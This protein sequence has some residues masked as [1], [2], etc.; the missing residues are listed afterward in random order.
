MP[1]PIRTEFGKFPR[2]QHR[3]SIIIHP[4]LITPTPSY[5][6]PRWNFRKANCDAFTRD[7][8]S[9]ACSLDKHCK[10]NI[11]KC[12]DALIYSIKDLAKKHIPRGFRKTYV[13]GWNEEC[14]ILAK[15]HQEEIRETADKLIDHLE[16]TRTERWKQT[17][18]SIN[19]THSSREA[20]S[21][22]NINRLIGRKKSS[23]KQA[24]APRASED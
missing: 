15:Q 20:W 7:S 11:N 18:E 19:F 6:V 21:T 4:A 16:Q 9:L 23:T 10:G 8:E 17:V 14:D 1:S 12:Y 5:P 13:P 2:S 22:I 24:N 3:P